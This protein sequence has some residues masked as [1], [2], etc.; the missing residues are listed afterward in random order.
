MLKFKQFKDNEVWIAV[1]I[2]DRFLFV[3]DEPY[4]IYV[5][6]DAMNA[7][8]FGHVLSRVE[9]QAPQE[10]DV[11]KLFQSALGSKKKQP[12][13][14]IVPDESKAGDIFRKLAKK[15]NLQVESVPLS[16]LSPIIAPLI[17]AFA[18]TDEE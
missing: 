3:N 7:H 6:M 13:K 8:V 17:A 10:S 1:R 16:E 14:I 18:E 11:E 2:N 15:Y 12:K 9:D 4:D 5:L